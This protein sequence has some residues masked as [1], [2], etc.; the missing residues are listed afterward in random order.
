MIIK[1]LQD[2]VTDFCCENY[3]GE[4]YPP[5]FTVSIDNEKIDNQKILLTIENGGR[6]LTNTVFPREDSL[7]GY[8]KLDKMMINMYNKTM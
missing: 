2:Y 6:V 8:D 3:Q 7:Y 4:S 1:I 5:K